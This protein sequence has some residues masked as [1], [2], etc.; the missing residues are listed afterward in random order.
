MGGG[1]GSGFSS[2]LLQALSTSYEKKVRFSYNIYPPPSASTSPL[3]IYNSVFAANSIMEHSSA[4]IV[5]EN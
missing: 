4:S 5:V 3:E 2:L 1:T